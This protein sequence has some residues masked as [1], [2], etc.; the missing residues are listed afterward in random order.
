M[1]VR[2]LLSTS[3]PRRNKSNQS[4]RDLWPKGRPTIR[5]NCF[6]ST[7]IPEELSTSSPS[8]SCSS[9]SFAPRSTQNRSTKATPGPP[10]RTYSPSLSTS[11]SSSTSSTTMPCSSCRLPTGGRRTCPKSKTSTRWRLRPTSSSTNL[12]SRRLPKK[13]ISS[14]TQEFLTTPSGLLTTNW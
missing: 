12:C 9:S 5:P 2:F 1:L 4:T 14:T 13:E 3:H 7:T 6:C 8:S 11:S 10:C